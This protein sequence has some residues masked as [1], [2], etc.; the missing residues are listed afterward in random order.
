MSE[1]ILSANVTIAALDPP[2]DEEVAVALFTL[3]RD[4]YAV[5]AATIGDDRIPPLHESLADLRSAELS[6]LGAWRAGVLVGAAAF[7]E[8]PDCV[9]LDRLVVAPDAHR[10]GV[11]TA[12]VRGVLSRAGARRTVVS[13][14]RDNGPACA[15]YERSGF[16]RVGVAEVLPGLWVQRFEHRPAVTDQ[17]PV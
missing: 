16:A 2:A 1:E 13:T 11:G 4:A 12:L 9:D 15:L 10:R 6:W 7:D 5:E 14:G 17:R 3:Q 8:T